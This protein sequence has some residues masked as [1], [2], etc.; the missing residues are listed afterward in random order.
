LAVQI[1]G[2]PEVTNGVVFEVGNGER[3]KPKGADEWNC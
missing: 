3:L 2:T 1:H